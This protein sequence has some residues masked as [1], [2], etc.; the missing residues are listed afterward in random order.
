MP[1]NVPGLLDCLEAL[2]GL[3]K[4]TSIPKE[5]EKSIKPSK[6]CRQFC[7][8]SLLIGPYLLINF[9]HEA[10]L[11]HLWGIWFI[12]NMERK[13]NHKP[14]GR[15]PLFFPSGARRQKRKDDKPVNTF[16]AFDNGPE[17]ETGEIGYL[18]SPFLSTVHRSNA[19]YKNCTQLSNICS[20]WQIWD[21]TTLLGK[22]STAHTQQDT[23]HCLV[24]KQ[25]FWSKLWQ[26][27][28]ESC[29]F[30]CLGQTFGI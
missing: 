17:W 9:T 12:N 6:L 7:K 27:L 22:A 13:R 21:S 3:G 30:Q 11:K 23:T 19:I 8:R 16:T 10:H 25:W 1:L 5:G 29:W 24:K 2:S 28:L 26:R 15:L 14:A 4:D 20:L 18:K